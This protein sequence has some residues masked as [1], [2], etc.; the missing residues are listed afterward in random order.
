DW[1]TAQATIDVRVA[2]TES[3]DKD[4]L[5]RIR[6][7]GLIFFAVD[8]PE[9]DEERGYRPVSPLGFRID[10]GPGFGSEAAI[11]RGVPADCFVHWFFVQE[12]NRFM[13]VCGRIASLVWV[14]DEPHPRKTDSRA[15]F[16]GKR[17]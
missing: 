12:W 5:A 11:V 9:I 10:A 2:M 15:L 3:Q 1:A 6:I 13:H 7:E 14:E 4:Q 17:V 16:P 8:P